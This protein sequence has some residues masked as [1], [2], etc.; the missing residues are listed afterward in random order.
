MDEQMNN[1][2]DTTAPNKANL[3]LLAFSLSALP[4]LLLFIDNYLFDLSYKAGAL[5]Y[6]V[7]WLSPAVGFILGIAMLR[8]GKAR[9]G[10]RGKRF[11]LGAL[12][13]PLPFI[14][15]GVLILLVVSRPGYAPGM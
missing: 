1:T 12:I 14:I 3:P 8:R 7:L 9:I 13:L 10:S 2:P 5:Y 11:S 4:Y 6:L 15:S